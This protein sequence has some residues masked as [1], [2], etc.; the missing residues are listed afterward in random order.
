[1]GVRGRRSGS[2]TRADDGKQWLG[3]FFF[4]SSSLLLHCFRSKRRRI[5]SPLECIHVL[6]N[7]EQSEIQ[8]NLL[9]PFLR[10]L[11]VLFKRYDNNLRIHRQLIGRLTRQYFWG[12]ARVLVELLGE[13]VDLPVPVVRLEQLEAE[14]NVDG[15]IDAVL[16]RRIQ[17]R[18]HL[19]PR[20]IEG[21]V[22]IGSGFS[23]NRNDDI[24]QVDWGEGL[25][26]RLGVLAPVVLLV[27]RI[28]R[29]CV[30]AKGWRARQ[31]PLQRRPCS[32]E[33]RGRICPTI[34]AVGMESH[35]SRAGEKEMIVNIAAN[36]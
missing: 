10:L 35:R 32:E 29:L 20:E 23:L 30:S 14:I 15:T 36:D 5:S 21:D 28:P 4:G 24:V 7:E 12:V 13:S 26:L 6:A 33:R 25:D 18:H 34:Q 22:G 16:H 17:R 1:M 3:G 2:S 27:L 19:R 9:L 8:M 31:R 11:S